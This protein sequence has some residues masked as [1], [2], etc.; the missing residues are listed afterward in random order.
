MKSSRIIMGLLL[1]L[2]GLF[3]AVVGWLTGFLMMNLVAAVPLVIIGLLMLKGKI[4]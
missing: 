2:I 1:I 4:K 3:I